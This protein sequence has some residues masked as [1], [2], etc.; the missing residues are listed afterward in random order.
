MQTN[1]KNSL[2]GLKEKR[3]QQKKDIIGFLYKMGELSK[4]E[5]CRLTNMTTPTISRMIDELIEEGWVADRGQGASIGGK[6]P[7]IFSLNPDAAYVI[8][9]DV[10]RIYLKIAIFNLRKEVIGEIKIFSSILEYNK[11]NEENITYIKQ[12]IAQSLQELNIPYNKIKVAGFAIPG[13]IDNEG[14]SYTYFVYDDKNIQSVLEQEL[15]IPVFIDN[16][17]K[18]MAMAEHTFGVAK[19]IANAL[20]ISVNECIGLGMILNSV[21]YTG[22]KGMAGEFGHIRISGLNDQCYCGKMGCLETVASGRAII[23]SANEAIG[24]GINTAINSIANGK[25]VTLETIIKAAKQDDMFA[26]DLLQAAGEK[27]GEGI[28]T[29]IHLYNPQ[30]L[31]IGGEI[32]DAGDLITAP[33]QQ[34]LNKYTLTRLKNQ[35]EIKLSN[36]N[37]HSTIMG[38]LMV[39]MK[40]LYYNSESEFTLY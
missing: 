40:N 5:I 7:H 14:T 25:E 9:V 18:I 24:N 23:K 22:Y 19:G 34:I 21:P 8:G 30:V 12:K 2:P 11:T 17:S 27:I 35:C 29:L 10:G 4:P 26:I 38:T 37:T 28:S 20:C 32:V 16:D 39:V 13:L 33:I 36:L 31:V 1:N 6:R 3:H 15:G